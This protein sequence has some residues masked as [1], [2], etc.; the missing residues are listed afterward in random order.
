MR[1]LVPEWSQDHDRHGVKDAR[2]R[3]GPM[4]PG[5]SAFES[6]LA[7]LPAVAVYPKAARQFGWPWN[8]RRPVAAARSATVAAAP[9]TL[10]NIVSK[11]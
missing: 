1:G 11:S 9:T 6:K 5:W 10:P 7:A 4:Q 3:T 2:E 8:Q